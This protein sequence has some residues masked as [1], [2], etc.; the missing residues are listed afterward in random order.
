[1]FTNKSKTMNARDYHSYMNNPALVRQ[2][3]IQFVCRLTKVQ[4]LKRGSG[5]HTY[6]GNKVCE[7]KLNKLSFIIQDVKDPDGMSRIEVV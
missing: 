3:L 4:F 1:M 7:K 5:I 2:Q 6:F